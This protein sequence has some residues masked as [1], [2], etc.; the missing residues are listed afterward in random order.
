M[1]LTEGQ[2]S[3]SMMTLPE[4]FADRVPEAELREVI[5][6]RNAGEWDQTVADL[7]AALHRH[8][9]TISTREV[10]SLRDYLETF[11]PALSQGTAG[12]ELLQT[13]TRW[14]DELRV[15]PSLTDEQ[16]Q[17][18]LR[19]LAERFRGRIPD[20]A[21]E[22]LVIRPEDEAEPEVW[23]DTADILVK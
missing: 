11:R 14:L 5:F 16:M 21:V 7:I 8:R 6:W 13:V 10:Q 12:L 4:R 15:I 2:V 20:E 1:R 23:S 9:T 17:E 18:R 22:D 3:Y 19:T